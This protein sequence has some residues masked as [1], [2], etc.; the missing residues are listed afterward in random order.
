MSSTDTFARVVIDAATEQPGHELLRKLATGEVAV[1]V[2]RNLLPEEAFTKNRERIG[3]L[4]ANASTT[5]YS[6]GTL[7]TIGPYLAKHLSDLD[8]Y[9]QESKD[10]QAML[11]GVSF[12]LAERVRE[13]LRKAF[14]LDSLEPAREP[15]GREYAA[16]VVRI[17]AD[18]VRNPLHND[19]IMRDAADTGIV[20]AGLAQQLSCVVCVQECDEGGELR[21]YRR[22]W[23]PEDE[24]FK[25]EGGL[26]YDEGVVEGHPGHEFKPQAG[27]V[28]V[29]NPMQYHS[30]E[31]VSG[32]DRITM[33]FFLGFADEELG[34]AVVWG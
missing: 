4:F 28:Y 25:I 22:P 8:T 24:T 32:S 20:L 19:N 10:A 5:S 1:V 34:S 12:D 31:R 3:E 7:T 17:H 11:D 13:G 2:L 27:D 26:G 30:I 29:I 21:I 9:F 6:N 23:Q 15:D 14:G 18:G 16:S 33:G